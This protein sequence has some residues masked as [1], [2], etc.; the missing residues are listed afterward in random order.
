MKMNNT[1]QEDI[2]PVEQTIAELADDD[3]PLLNAR[4]AD[5]SDLTPQQLSLLDDTW[6]KIEAG[7]RRQIIQRLV[8]LAEDDVCLNFDS[9]FKRRLGDEDEGIRHVAVNGLWE[10]E[11]T[12]L[13]ATFINL[14]QT[15]NS[16]KVQAA[17]ACALG[18]FSMLAEHCKINTD[19]ALRLSQ[20]LLSVFN[21]I[22]KAVEVRR[23][24]LEAVSPLSQQS[25]KQ[26][27]MEAYRSSNPLLKTSAI[28]AMGKNC[29]PGWLPLLI[30]ELSSPDA[31]LRYEAATACGELGEEESV[32]HLIELSDDND[33]EVQIAAVQ[34][35]GKIGGSEARQHL[36]K[37][38]SSS[39]EAIRQV[40]TQALHELELIIEPVSGDYMDF[41]ELSD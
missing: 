27:I 29:D 11:E 2:A 25:V 10:N 4:L 1:E 31:S 40:A 32:S 39:S 37:C 14:M 5:L 35:L 30:A 22:H 6:Q 18:R 28:Y 26:A 12:S 19:H 17:A 21:D 34:A 8:E 36:E 24:A 33:S 23:R 41:G 7:R 15:D 13:I 20:A 9:V 38:L 3:Q 16:V